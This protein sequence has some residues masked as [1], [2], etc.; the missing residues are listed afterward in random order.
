MEHGRIL[1]FGVG[2]RL[3]G[4]GE[5]AVHVM[6]VRSGAVRLT[7]RVFAVE[8]TLEELGRGAVCG[9][10]AFAENTVYPV[11]AMALEATE[12]MALTPGEFGSAL[13]IDPQLAQLVIRKLSSRVSATHHRISVMG[14]RSIEGRVMLQLHWENLRQGGVA[15]D[16]YAPI[17]YDLPAVIAAEE[18][19]VRV[20]LERLVRDG[21]IEVDG[22]GR[23]RISSAGAWERR[24]QY[25]ELHDR[26]GQP[27]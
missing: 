22:A 6:V 12:V 3:F 9:E 16:A 19:Q 2:E 26:F 20:V 25:L 7:R 5:P 17:P 11:S 27:A 14:M 10:S 23:F 21:L 8:M 24:L 4:E 15:G 18:A 1:K 13:H